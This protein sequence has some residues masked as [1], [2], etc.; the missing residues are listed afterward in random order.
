[1]ESSDKFFPVVAILVL[2]VV[3]TGKSLQGDMDFIQS[4]T[5]SH[6]RFSN[7]TVY[8]I[9]S[10]FHVLSCL[11]S[12]FIQII[13]SLRSFF[14]IILALNFLHQQMSFSLPNAPFIFLIHL[15]ISLSP[16]FLYTTH[17]SLL[18]N[19]R[20]GLEILRALA[21]TIYKPPLPPYI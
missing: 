11:R 8:I 14:N 13:Y 15:Y 21:N 2:L 19:S 3:A 18:I 1:M 4:W 16:Y 12:R 17:F 7:V 10:G 5:G 6:E 20:A 9:H